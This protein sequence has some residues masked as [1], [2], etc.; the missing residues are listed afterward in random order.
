M[1]RYNSSLHS[2]TKHRSDD[3]LL[4][5][6]KT[7]DRFDLTVVL[8]NFILDGRERLSEIYKA[9]HD[10]NK[11]KLIL[12]VVQMKWENPIEIKENQSTFLKYRETLKNKS[13]SRNVKT[14]LTYDLAKERLVL[15]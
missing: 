12:S 8:N 9:I 3:V 5:N 2:V 10:R 1:L 13:N 7:L 14:P 11:Q 15:V 4:G 6:T